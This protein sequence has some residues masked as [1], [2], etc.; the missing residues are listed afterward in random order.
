[1]SEE[2]RTHVFLKPCGCLVAAMIDSPHN[3]REL[4]NALRMALKRG[5]IY[6]VM[7]TQTVRE[8]SWTCEKHKG[9]A[10]KGEE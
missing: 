7:E 4:G 10:P 3:Y 5:E 8:M 2:P 9:L 1:M 6:K